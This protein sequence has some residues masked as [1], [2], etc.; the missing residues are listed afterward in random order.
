MEISR[1]TQYLSAMSHAHPSDMEPLR[2]YPFV[3]IS[4]QTGAAAMDRT[5]PVKILFLAGLA[6]MAG[7]RDSEIEVYQAPK[8]KPAGASPAAPQE[9]P[10]WR[11]PPGWREGPKGEMRAASFRVPA[12]EEAAELSVVVLDGEAGGITANVNR[13]RGQI[14]LGALDEAGLEKAAQRVD[15][16]AGTLQLFDFVGAGGD[17]ASPTKE[18]L[19]AAILPRRQQTWFFKLTGTQRA[20][21]AAKP[22]FLE[23]LRSLH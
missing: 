7:C 23:F 2:P 21:A 19:A 9:P 8:D 3:A 10:S 5:L 17:G 13:W 16:A 14:G 6:A 15:S 12:G 20:V 18:R 4:R 1:L 11:V 22:S